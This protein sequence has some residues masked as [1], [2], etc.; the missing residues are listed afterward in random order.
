MQVACMHIRCQT[1]AHPWPSG[2][3]TEHLARPCMSVIS[4]CSAHQLVG[5]MTLEASARSYYSKE[6]AGLPGLLQVVLKRGI[7]ALPSK[8]FASFV[9]KYTPSIQPSVAAT[10]LSVIVSYGTSNR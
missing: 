7:D 9:Q 2:T 5:C 6:Q 1:F 3:L 10:R 8:L 4:E